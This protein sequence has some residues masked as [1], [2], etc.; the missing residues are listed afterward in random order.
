MS[1]IYSMAFAY[2]AAT[3]TAGPAIDSNRQFILGKYACRAAAPHG[4]L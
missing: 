3:G 1:E 4:I 2:S